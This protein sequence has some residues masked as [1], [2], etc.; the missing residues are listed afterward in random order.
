MPNNIELDDVVHRSK[1]WTGIWKSRR[2]LVLAE[3]EHCLWPLCIAG[4]LLEETRE[5]SSRVIGAPIARSTAYL[6]PENETIG[7][8]G[9]AMLPQV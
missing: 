8:R 5:P 2:F 1:P 9:G 6:R 4:N 7:A 3:G